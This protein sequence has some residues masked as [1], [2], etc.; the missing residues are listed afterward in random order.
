MTD[1]T[2]LMSAHQIHD[3]LF[4]MHGWPQ[5]GPTQDDIEAINRITDAYMAIAKRAK[6]A[7]RRVRWLEEQLKNIYIAKAQSTR[8]DGLELIE[9]AFAPSTMAFYDDF[10]NIHVTIAPTPEDFK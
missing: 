8:N 7:E 1:N 3:A 4:R 2:K 5:N 10:M 9:E 6:E